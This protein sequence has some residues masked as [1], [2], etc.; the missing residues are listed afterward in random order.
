MQTVDCIQKES[1][2]VVIYV[3]IVSLHGD[4]V[5]LGHTEASHCMWK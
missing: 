2:G 5:S 4:G 3:W 1:H